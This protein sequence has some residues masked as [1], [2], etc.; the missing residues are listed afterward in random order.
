MGVRIYPVIPA[1]DPGF[2]LEPDLDEACS[3]PKRATPRLPG[4]GSFVISLLGRWVFLRMIGRG[5][6]R[7]AKP[8]QQLA[9]RA[10]GHADRPAGRDLR[11]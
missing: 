8:A 11:L 4:W 6:S 10:L 7:V 3:Q 1:P 9:D 5:C 2:V